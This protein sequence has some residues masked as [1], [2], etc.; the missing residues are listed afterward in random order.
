MLE[1][2]KGLVSSPK[3]QA[4][5]KEDSLKPWQGRKHFHSKRIN[6]REK[7]QFFYFHQYF[8]PFWLPNRTHSTSSGDLFPERQNLMLLLL[9]LLGRRGIISKAAHVLR[10]RN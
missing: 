7:G 1:Q 3:E 9:K 4:A 10:T 5:G 2:D 8:T 6:L